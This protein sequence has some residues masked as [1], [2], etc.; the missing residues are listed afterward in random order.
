MLPARTFLWQIKK[1]CMLSSSPS[2]QTAQFTG[3]C[4]PRLIS[5]TRVG[6]TL[7]PICHRIFFT[8][9]G[10]FACHIR[11]QLP[12]MPCLSRIP[13]L[14]MHNLYALQNAFCSA[15][16]EQ[17]R[18]KVSL[19]SFYIVPML[20]LQPPCT[21]ELPSI[22]HVFGLASFLSVLFNSGSCFLDAD[23]NL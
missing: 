21:T 10:I 7:W 15:S 8:L 13:A 3:H 6:K 17:V 5:L 22:A 9:G 20:H 14:L 4:T 23:C 12:V 1:T 2:L 19:P 11:F 16:V 18:N